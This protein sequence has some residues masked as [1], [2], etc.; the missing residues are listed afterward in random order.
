MTLRNVTV[1]H[2]TAVDGGGINA[3]RTHLELDSCTVT[4]N[5]AVG[6]LGG[7]IAA[8]TD[9]LGST[10][11]SNVTL[12]RNRAEHGG[13]I[14]IFETM[15]DLAGCTIRDNEAVG[16]A[17]GGI[18]CSDV[19]SV[20]LN[21]VTLREN[22]ATWGGGLGAAGSTILIRNCRFMRNSVTWLGGALAADYCEIDIDSVRF[23]ENRADDAGGGNH[24]D[25]CTV[26]IWDTQYDISVANVGG[27]INGDMSQLTLNRCKFAGDTASIGAGINARNSDLILDNTLFLANEVTTG[28]GAIQYFADTTIFD[29]PYS[30][31][32][33]ESRFVENN[34]TLRIA[35]VE[36]QQTDPDS[37]IIDVLVDN[38]EFVDNTADR[39]T[40]FRILGSVSGFVFS[41]SVV[42]G[43]TS[44]VWLA[45]V[46]FHS[47]C[48]GTV[49]NCLFVS[50]VAGTG[51]GTAAA[52]VAG[53]SAVDFVNC[54]FAHN[55]GGAGSGLGLRGL[56]TASLTNCIFWGGTQG[57]IGV[58]TVDTLGGTL[59][60]NYSD[61]QHGL[62]SIAVTDSF[63]VVHWGMGNIDADPLF[64]DTAG[65]DYSLQN[66]SPCI[67]A[68]VDSFQVAGAW[69]YAPALDI[70]GNP[71]PAPQGTRSD[72]GAFENQTTTPVGVEETDA[73]GLPAV[74]ALLQNYPNPFNP[75]TTIRYD[76]PVSS[77][78]VITLYGVL[79]E[80]VATV[81]DE[82][83]DAGYRSAAF[84]ATGLASGV[85]FYRI[86][87]LSTAEGSRGG[88]VSTRKMMI[89]K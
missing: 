18:Q 21:D 47:G 86:Q 15:L 16:H 60:V 35:G 88:F 27:G 52:G 74:Y 39:V 89:L 20:V 69:I 50:N 5:Q 85:Y 38:C 8:S 30:V 28:G 7:G 75:A 79:G 62:D 64:S 72:I 22:S 76:L 49:S 17:G 34:S 36:I 37:S 32:L 66:A 61:I 84:D 51:T 41:N 6:G 14:H 31:Q 25:H 78:V 63:S 59:H 1:A 58:A 83:Q 2:N 3:Y 71:R 33:K 46:A 11:L 13:G 80:K 44:E 53:G 12:A 81:V 24:F 29:R 40:A 57:Q 45:G 73:E 9:S 87:A 70:A 67:G 19:D 65:H 23:V 43:N 26:E 4:D 48:T 42:G 68:G 77:R 55:D 82:V 56:A 10:T 54:T